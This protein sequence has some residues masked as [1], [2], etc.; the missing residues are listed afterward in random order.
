MPLL[1]KPHLIPQRRRRWSEEAEEEEEEEEEGARGGGRAGD[2]SAEDA[3][4]AGRRGHQPGNAKGDR[5]G[6]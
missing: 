4:W 3:G 2:R 1:P 5:S 6:V